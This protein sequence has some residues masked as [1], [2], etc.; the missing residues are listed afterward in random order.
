V[1]PRHVNSGPRRAPDAHSPTG[2]GRRDLLRRG[3]VMLYAGLR[4]RRH[5]GSVPAI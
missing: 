2:S 3:A 5:E 1:V 4:G